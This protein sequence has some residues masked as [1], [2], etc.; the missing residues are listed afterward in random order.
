VSERLLL[1]SLATV[2]SV[3]PETLSG[4]VRTFQVEFDDP[5]DA[6]RFTYLPGQCAMVSVFGVGECMIS[7]ASSPTR[8]GPLEFAVKKVGMVTEAIHELEP[9][10]N[11]GVRGP[12]GN[13]FPAH[14]WLGQNLLFVAGGIGLAPLRSLVN[15]CLDKREDYGTIDLV[16]GARTPGDLCFRDELQEVWS[17]APDTRVN[18]TVDRGDDTWAG[19]V[20]FVPAFLESLAP[21]PSGRIAVTCGPPI[22]I[23]LVLESLTRLG[24]PPERII[25]TLEMKMQCGVG[26]CGRCNVGAKYVCVDGPV[27]SLRDL[28]GLPEEF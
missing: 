16:Y 28:E 8:L 20:G 6:A 22:M 21:D 10:A 26:K 18:L 14:N 27:F 24:F 15:Y 1:P 7:I 3:R 9:G 4:D 5:A 13:C 11:L 12:Y 25:T 2:T 17:K 19:P 23:K